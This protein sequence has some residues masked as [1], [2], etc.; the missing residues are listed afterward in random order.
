MSQP[1]TKK[2]AQL[3]PRMMQEGLQEA[4]VLKGEQTTLG[5]HPSNDIVVALDSISRFHARMDRRGDFF[6]LQDLNSA[7]GTF[8]NGERITQIALHN[9]DLVMFGNI[10]FE[11][12]NDEV[13]TSAQPTWSGKDI[14]DIQDD[15]GP[16]PTTHSYMKVEEVSQKKKSS[17]I[18]AADEKKAD[19][20]TLL[21]L[22]HQLRALYSLSELLRELDVDREDFVLQRVLELIFDAVSADRGVF[23]TRFHEDAEQLD[24]TAVKYRDEPIVP[25]KVRVSRTILDQVLSEKVAV[26]SRDAQADDRF[27][28]SESIIASKVR[29]AICAP[30]IVRDKVLGVLFVDTTHNLRQFSKEDLEFVMIVANE[31]GVALAAIRMHKEAIHRQRLAAVGETVAHISHNVRNILLLSQGGAELLT[32]AL[33][34]EDMGRAKDAW[35]VVSRG[36]ERIG[37]LVRD[38][39]E[40]S[41][42]KQTDLEE[43]NVNELI[44]SIAEDI[45]EKLVAKSVSLELDLDEGI[46]PRRLNEIGLQRTLMN[47]I[48]NSLDAIGH[49]QGRIEVSTT[50]RE[51]KAVVIVIRDN[52]SGIPQDKLEKIFFPFYTTKSQGTGLGLPMCKKCVEDMGGRLICES[53]ENVGTTF[54][55]ELPLLD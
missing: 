32:A 48:V 14:L 2:P 38:M 21:K 27:N 16:R 9:G 20:A 55:I 31:T 17:V 41:S 3:I 37:T 29:S 47:L 28:S 49:Q 52:G 6:I 7:N 44:C 13:A 5:R 11:F 34:K 18:S 46:G 30:L 24:V 19:K 45:E 22:N 51:D 25:E 42:N 15:E 39:L 33:A 53:Q 43:V 23:L 35:Q 12:Q 8:V 40:F 1:P 26:L 10:E 36:I 50:L 4:Y 54:I